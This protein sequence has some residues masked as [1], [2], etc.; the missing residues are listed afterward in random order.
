MFLSPTQ[1]TACRR[2]CCFLVLFGIAFI[3]AVLAPARAQGGSGVDSMGTGGRHS[4]QGRIYFPSGRRTDVQV[5][6]RL[7]NFNAGALSVLSDANGSFTFRGLVPGSYTVVVDGGDDYETARE[8]VYIDTDGSNPSRG[9]VLPTPSRLYTVDISLHVKRAL[10]AKPGVLSA[11]LAN[12]PAPARDL[13]QAALQSAHSGDHKKAVEQLK[14]ALANYPSFPL[15]LNELGVQYL[16][17]EQ[18][19]KAV[20]V[21]SEAIK[22]SPSE[23]TPRLNFGYALLQSNRLADAEAQ[24][25]QAL[26]KNDNSWPGHMYLGMTL[27]RLHRYDES[28]LELQRSLAVAGVDLAMPHYYLAGVYWAKNDYKRAADELEKYLKLAPGTP[29]AE[30]TRTTIKDLRNK[31]LRGKK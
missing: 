18:P 27:G 15:A 1:T 22:L 16:T 2:R 7:E 30:R 14:E 6:V 4:I 12:I 25:R 31:E 26:S 10:T 19:E 5:R 20:E 17:L 3:L 13:Y 8:T 24:L 11:E 21:L 29:D 28:E 9:I 23:F